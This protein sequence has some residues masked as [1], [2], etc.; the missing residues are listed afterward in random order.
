VSDAAITAPDPPTGASVGHFLQ[1][2]SQALSLPEPLRSSDR[3]AYL[4]LLE[5]RSRVVIMSLDRLAA[6]PD[7]DAT[8]FMSEGDH[9]LHQIADLPPTTYRHRHPGQ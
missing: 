3:P 9:I 1:A 7:A 2:A 8:D 6:N 4:A 5:Q